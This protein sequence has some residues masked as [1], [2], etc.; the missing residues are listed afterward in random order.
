MSDGRMLPW[1]GA[2]SDRVALYGDTEKIY[3]DSAGD[4]SGLT[5]TVMIEYIKD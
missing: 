2:H 3:V 4:Y 5:A 1:G